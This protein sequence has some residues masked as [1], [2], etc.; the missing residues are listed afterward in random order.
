M[1]RVI[2]DKTIQV[3]AELH[4]RIKNLANTEA[5]KQNI[6]YMSMATYLKQMLDKHKL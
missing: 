5:V 4:Q 3:P 2:T 1:P 6:P